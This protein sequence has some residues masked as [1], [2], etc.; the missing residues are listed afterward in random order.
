MFHLALNDNSLTR[1][2]FNRTDNYKDWLYN[3]DPTIQDSEDFYYL[4][5]DLYRFCVGL[6]NI[7]Y[8]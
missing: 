1:V 2:Y 6:D 3:I 5:D 8:V 7:K 4:G